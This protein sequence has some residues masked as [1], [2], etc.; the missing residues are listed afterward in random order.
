M[1]L[2]IPIVGQVLGH[3]RIREQIGAGGM[4]LVFL[5]TDRSDPSTIHHVMLYLGDGMIAEAPYQ[6]QP[7]RTAPLS[8]NEPELV[9]LAT[10]PGTAPHS[11]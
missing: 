6:G 1:A 4:G 2:E 7:V 11:A 8:W 5:A 9:P 3:Y 10:R